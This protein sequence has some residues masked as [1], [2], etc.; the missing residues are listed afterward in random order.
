MLRYKIFALLLLHALHPLAQPADPHRYDERIEHFQEKDQPDSIRRYALE[1]IRLARAADSLA[2]WGWAQLDRYYTLPDND[3]AAPALLDAVWAERWREPANAYDTEPFLYLQTHRGW[4]LFQQGRVW[5]S[6]QAYE[7]ARQWYEQFQYA[8]FDAVETLYKPL[9]NHYTRLGDNAKALAVFQKTLPLT[10]APAALAGLYSNIGIAHW[11]ARQ[12]PEALVAFQQGLALPGLPAERRAQL[13]GGFAQAQLDAGQPAEALRNALVAAHSPEP[14]LQAKTLRTAANAHLRL[15]RHTDAERLLHQ[16]LAAAK[17]AYGPHD[18]ELS[19]TENDLAK[20]HL[21]L[22]RPKPALAAANRALVAVLPHFQPKSPLENP[23]AATF[24]EENAIWEALSSKAAAAEMQYHN[25]GDLAWLRCAAYCHDV[26]R[27]AEDRHREVFQYETSKL[28]LQRTARQREEAAMHVARLLFEKTGQPAHLEK[29]FAIAERSKAA[30]LLDALRDNLVRQRLAGSDPRFGQLTDLRRSRAFFEKNLLLDPRSPLAPQLRSEAD[31]LAQQIADLQ[32]VLAAAYPRLSEAENRPS[33]TALADATGA[34]AEG[35]M[36]LEYFVGQQFVEVFVVGRGRAPVW[37]RFPNDATLQAA[38]ATFGSFFVNA[39]ALLD[40]PAGYLQAA[41][42]LC[43]KIL[44]SDAATAQ[45]L[46]IVP[47]GFLNTL[48]FEA[49]I[50]AAPSGS[51]NLRNA[52]YLLRRQ[53]VRYAWS[54]A[55]LRQQNLLGSGAKQY[56]LA[57]APVCQQGVRGL[58]PLP[59]SRSEWPSLRAGAVTELIDRQANWPQVSGAAENYRVLHF[60]TH[61]YAAASGEQPPRIELYDR[62]AYLPDIYALPLQADLVVLSACQTGLGTEQTGE[63]VMSLA[64]AFAQS[65]A[66]CVVSSLWAVNDRSTAQLF[67]YFYEKIGAGEPV[68]AALHEAKLAYLND[69]DVPATLQSPYFWAGVV[70]VGADRTVPPP[71]GWQWVWVLVA[72]ALA[73][74]WVW[75]RW[76]AKK[77]CWA[78][79][80]KVTLPQ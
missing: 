27:Q 68:C 30:L 77:R 61:A 18:R 78:K 12:Y 14:G 11:N 58:S 60:S 17:T 34:L 76:A 25:N 23:D 47:D 1:K 22:H 46:L 72:G 42:E 33:Q 15:G 6:V 44:P 70:A 24:Y 45:R 8:D 74:L 65:G 41:F 67:G 31:V 63:G 51:T 35:E 16:A 69:P 66:A 9:G 10:H 38:A 4:H 59:A 48:P 56:L 7:Q 49:L 2:A 55:T 71:Q 52:P 21:T 50:T 37:H 40:A 57:V 20:L 73:T 75:C 5:Q 13:L 26:A 29:A 53:A 62:A 19:K 32:R 80:E 54:V 3:P 39:H 43:Q 36:L 28:D 79:I 64:R